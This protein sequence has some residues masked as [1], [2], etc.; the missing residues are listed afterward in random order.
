MTEL[1][2]PLTE[3]L[4]EALRQGATDIHLDGMEDC[5]I[6]RM[7]VEGE[8]SRCRT[9]PVEQAQKIVNQLKV[10]AGMEPGMSIL[11]REGQF[12]CCLESRE[13]DVRATVVLTADRREAAHLRILTPPQWHRDLRRLGL[14]DE[15]SSTIR[16]S[17]DGLHGL[18]LIAGP[19]G[20]G[21]TTTAYSM[22]AMLDCGR[23]VAASIEDPAE[24]DLQNVRQVEV[25][26]RRGLT[27]EEG[28]RS[29]L[30]MDPDIVLVGEVR[31]RA[32]AEIA[33]R[34]ALAGRLVLATIHARD[35]VSA[36][37]AMHYLSVP[38]YVLGS[39]L[40]LIVAQNLVRRLCP[41]CVRMEVPGGLDQKVFETHGLELPKQVPHAGGCDH[42]GGDGY[43]GRTGVFEVAPVCEEASG[44]ISRGA[45]RTEILRTLRQAGAEPIVVDALKKVQAGTMS[46]DDALRLA[47]L[48]DSHSMNSFASHEHVS[49]EQ[50]ERR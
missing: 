34:A 28:L 3:I 23:V 47:G 9:V 6:L 41:R 43:L 2:A 44:A 15:Q 21:K 33:G 27:M 50:E 38:Y 40:R 39:G 48:G 1:P 20:S 11:P 49:K 36:I 16:E 37:Q 32:S 45:G 17:L 10:A 14:D 42:C 8:I 22:L 29:I 13:I 46:M 4:Q 35:A 5:A 30:R 26:E 19:S 24:F 25:D 7:R 31:D 18:V 12:H